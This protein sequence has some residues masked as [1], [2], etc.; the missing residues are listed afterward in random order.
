M[1]AYID[2]RFDPLSGKW[3][4]SWSSLASPYAPPPRR[5]YR[6]AGGRLRAGEGTGP[7]S[8]VLVIVPAEGRG[9]ATA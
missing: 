4:P 5:S 9:A 8:A 6:P 7:G 3:V 1:P 2:R